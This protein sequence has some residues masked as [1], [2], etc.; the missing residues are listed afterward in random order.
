MRVQRAA[1]LSLL[2]GSMAVGFTAAL[3]ELAEARQRPIALVRFLAGYYD[4]RAR[5]VPTAGRN[6]VNVDR[7]AVFMF[8]FSGAVDMGP[9]M[10]ATLPLT[11]AEQTA[12]EGE[13]GFEPGVIQRRVAPDAEARYVCSGTVDTESVQIAAPT[14]GGGETTA[15]GVF[16]RVPVPRRRGRLF[17]NRFTFNPRFA[18]ATFGN[19]REID[20]NPE[21][22][23]ANTTYN[24]TVDGGADPADPFNLVRNRGGVPLAA[25]FDAFFET[26][27]GYVQDFTRP[28]IRETTPTDLASGVASDA[29]IDMSFS[30]PMDLA[31]FR[32]PRFQA[33][34]EWTVRVAYTDSPSNGFLAGKNILGVMRVKPQTAGNVMQF[35]PLQ[36]FGPGPYEI[37][38]TITAGVTDLSGNNIIRQQRLVFTTV[39]DPGAAGAGQLEEPFSDDTFKGVP[40]PQGDNDSAYWPMATGDGILRTASPAS[41]PVPEKSFDAVSPNG[42]NNNANL[43]LGVPIHLHLLFPPNDLGGRPRTLTGFKWYRTTSVGQTYPNTIVQMAHANSVVATSGFSTAAPPGPVATNFRETPTLLFPSAPYT[44]AAATAANPIPGPTWVRNFNFDGSTALILDIAHGGH[45]AAVDERW[46]MDSTYTIG[47]LTYQV[48]GTPPGTKSTQVWYFRTNFSYLTPGAEARSLWYDVQLQNARYLPQIVI[49]TQQPQGTQ[50]VIEWQGAKSDPNNPS[51]LDPSTITTWV[52]DVRQLA[53]NPFLRFNVT[54][55]NNLVSREA[56]TVDTI[57]EPFTFQ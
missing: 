21:G 14:A 20:Y 15:R 18:A 29:D 5:F 13:E 11:L 37:A 51:V 54:L 33:D 25:R 6:A 30:E 27:S 52:T 12:L 49:P 19:P 2:A 26:G 23:E 31:S 36:G 8:T 38:V 39:S 1:V 4:R 24:V 7:N 22:L 34:D 32:L 40:Q 46:A 57:V 17:V 43:W 42:T 53:N 48:L 28:E 9:K 45:G 56:P 44:T 16:F 55:K 47:V 50:V 35:R 41:L 10:K 3:H